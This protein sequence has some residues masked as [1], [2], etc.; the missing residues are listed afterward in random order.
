MTDFIL[1]LPSPRL[2]KFPDL[3]R[4]ESCMRL[5]LLI[6]LQ[7]SYQECRLFFTSTNSSASVGA[8]PRSPRWRPR[9]LSAAPFIFMSIL[10]TI[11]TMCRMR[12]VCTLCIWQRDDVEGAE[13]RQSSQNDENRVEPQHWWLWL[14]LRPLGTS[15]GEWDW[16]WNTGLSSPYLGSP[17]SWR[18][19]GLPHQPAP[20]SHRAS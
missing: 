20:C 8:T 5:H 14:H 15:G 11:T 13:V 7:V 9:F 12:L 1:W 16:D 10:I 19:S 17:L 2:L 6:L 18:T 4:G 3:R